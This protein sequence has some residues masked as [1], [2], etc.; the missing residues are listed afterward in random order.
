VKAAKKRNIYIR[1][2][3][4]YVKKSKGGKKMIGKT[5]WTALIAV[6]MAVAFL[7]GV[8][9]QQT[10]IETGVAVEGRE[11]AEVAATGALGGLDLGALLGGGI[12]GLL[13]A[14][15]GGLGGVLSGIG[16]GLGGMI[17]FCS[18]IPIV[19]TLFTIFCLPLYTVCAFFAAKLYGMTGIFN[20][21]FACL[22]G[23]CS[24]PGMIAG[25]C[26]G[27]CGFCGLCINCFTP[28]TVFS[29]AAVIY[30]LIAEFSGA[31]LGC[32]SIC[33]NPCVAC[34]GLCGGIITSV[35]GLIGMIGSAIGGFLSAC[36]AVITGC[37]AAIPGTC[38]GGFLEFCIF[39]GCCI[40]PFW[41]CCWGIIGACIGCINPV[42][43]D[44]CGDI[45]CGLGCFG[46]TGTFIAMV[47]TELLSVCTFCVG[48]PIDCVSCI[49]GCAS[50]CINP[51]TAIAAFCS[52]LLAQ[53]LAFVTEALSALELLCSGACCVGGIGT[54]CGSLLGL[55]GAIPCG[56]WGTCKL[57]CI[58]A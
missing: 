53:L 21:I 38:L 41:D 47:V 8:F 54:F 28:D 46:G 16:G 43:F 57:P 9:A 34:A 45:L 23:V 44:L 26:A 14:L 3:D 20:Y 48:F 17:A 10:A 6:F 37:C 13:S 31:L 39:P 2:I 25:V 18:S 58:C 51:L 36:F 35:A 12:S 50:I 7:P 11:Q 55:C 19:G 15:G 1:A 32:L 4:I 42:C 29:I 30:G 22:S 56:A 27:I 5:G 40:I 24:I 49:D 33:V 52:G